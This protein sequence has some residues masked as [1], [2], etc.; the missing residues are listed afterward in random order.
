MAGA[1]EEPTEA[2]GGGAQPGIT[3]APVVH[4]MWEAPLVRAYNG[5]L[6]GEL[7]PEVGLLQGVEAKWAGEPGSEEEELVKEDGQGALQPGGTASA[8]MRKTQSRNLPTKFFSLH[9]SPHGVRLE[10]CKL[11]YRVNMD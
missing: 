6:G 2:A 4:Q 10:R 9:I 8:V 11:L 3:P 5:V 7:Q 1:D